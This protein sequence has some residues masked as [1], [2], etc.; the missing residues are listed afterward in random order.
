[1]GFWKNLGE[2]YSNVGEMYKLGW[3]NLSQGNVAGGIEQWLM[4]T[5]S[6]IGNTITLGGANAIGNAM[7]STVEDNTE[8]V[9]TVI[10]TDAN[11]EEITAFLPEYK[12]NNVATFLTSL[13][14]AKSKAESYIE[15]EQLVDSGEIGRAN[16]LGGIELASDAIDV[17]SVTAGVGAVGRAAGVGGKAAA[18]AGTEAVEAAAKETAK[19]TAK[20]AVKETGK[21]IAKEAVK[22]AAEEAGKTTGKSILKQAVAGAS[23]TASTA[24]KTAKVTATTGKSI[25]TVTGV[26]AGKNTLA[27]IPRTAVG[28]DKSVGLAATEETAKFGGEITGAATDM[29]DKIITGAFPGIGYMINTVCAGAHATSTMMSAT[30]AGAYASAVCTK[31]IDKVKSWIEMDAV[32]DSEKTI[33]EIAKKNKQAA[34]VNANKGWVRLYADR[35]KALDAEDGYDSTSRTLVRKADGIEELEEPKDDTP[36][37][38]SI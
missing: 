30:G 4:G 16:K 17:I 8:Y 31:A 34:A 14:G 7:Y 38:Q 19:T 28:E 35:V 23:K 33:S 29:G 32:G 9:E 36:E 6:G 10:G 5:A 11:G 13:T 22:E 18:A 3:D 2:A 27:R 20:A 12:E 24:A 26:L 25:L 15:Q 37:L 1:M 21:T